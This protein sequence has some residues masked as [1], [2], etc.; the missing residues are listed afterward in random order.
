MLMP[1]ASSAISTQ[2]L[3]QQTQQQ[4]QQSHQMAIDDVSNFQSK[5]KK[6]FNDSRD[7]NF[8]F[9]IMYIDWRTKLL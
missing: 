9:V 1:K 2:H 8:A 3:Q 5:C 7:I 4:Q 6:K